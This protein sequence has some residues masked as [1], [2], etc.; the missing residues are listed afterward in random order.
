MVYGAPPFQH[1]GGGPLPKM[2]AIA[3]PS[4]RIDYPETAAPRSNSTLSVTVDPTAID[5]MR[6]CLAYRKEQRLT[7][8]EL[9]T[10]EFL[11]P[12]RRG[13]YFDVPG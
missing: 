11:R 7:I 13:E 4:H 10:H 3:D 8:P 1:I 9:L 5:S 2:N 6:R 12:S